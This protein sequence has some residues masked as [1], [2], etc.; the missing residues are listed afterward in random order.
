MSSRLGRINNICKQYGM[1]SPQC[2]VPGC[3]EPIRM[4]HILPKAKGG[5]NRIENLMPMCIRHE[6]NIHSTRKKYEKIKAAMGKD[7]MGI[8]DFIRWYCQ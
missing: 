3:H 2:I 8:K 7:T 6:R 4:H 5:T 1:L